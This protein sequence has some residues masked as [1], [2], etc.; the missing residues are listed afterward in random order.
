MKTALHDIYTSNQICYG[1]SFIYSP[2]S[3]TI[4]IDTRELSFEEGGKKENKTASEV[5]KLYACSGLAQI[6]A[7]CIKKDD[8]F[9]IVGSSIAL[10][11]TDLQVPLNVLFSENEESSHLT[12]IRLTFDVTYNKK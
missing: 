7:A 2:V 10:N 12:L 6:L 11:Q 9:V 1:E 4:T 3:D 8:L 5:I